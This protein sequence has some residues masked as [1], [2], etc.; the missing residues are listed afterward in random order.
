MKKIKTKFGATIYVEEL[1][2]DRH[3]ADRE[4]E[5]KIK[6]FDTKE[7]YLNYFEVDTIKENAECEGI[8]PEQW[9]DNYTK[10]LADCD[11][12]TAL[13]R[14]M[15]VEWVYIS[16]DWKAVAAYMFHNEYFD[17]DERVS[18]KDL[19]ENEWVNVIGDQYVVIAEC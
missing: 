5:T 13:L 12:V 3:Y 8:S 6:F 19:L 17:Q 9:L 1:S 16:P 7:R 4:D 10:V 15:G 14:E 2:H 18:S 11:T